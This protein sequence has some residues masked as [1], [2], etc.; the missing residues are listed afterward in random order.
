MDLP[1]AL[2]LGSGG[3]DS[4]PAVKRTAA[5]ICSVAL[6]PASVGLVACGN[7]TKT[8]SSTTPSGE[9][10]TRTVPD[11]KFAKARFV[12][13]TGLAL[14]AFKRWI[15]DPW[16]A[17]TFSQGAEGRKK[18]LAKAGLAGV[19]ALTQL[20][21]ARDAALSDDQLRGLGDKLSSTIGLVSAFIPGLENGKISTVQIIALAGAFAGIKSLAAKDGAPVK[22]IIS[23]IPGF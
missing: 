1:T 16:K 12:L 4:F 20:K 15:Y 22:P 11:V 6:L 19:F 13:H 7:D 5:L 3:A 21:E 18:A 10:V 8:V 2:H 9:V 14:G 17:G 23:K